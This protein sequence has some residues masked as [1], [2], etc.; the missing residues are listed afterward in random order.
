M[1]NLK[2]LSEIFEHRLVRIPD[3][4][5]GYAWGKPQL[6][7]FWEDLL[8]LNSDRVH[9]TGVITLEPVDEKFYARWD[10][11]LWLIKGRGYKPFYVVD[12]QQR[13]T[14]SL[15]LIQAIL[16]SID[17]DLELNYQGKAEIKKHYIL[18][19]GKDGVRKSFFFGYEKDNPSSEF[20]K[21]SI[22]GEYSASNEDTLTLYTKNLADAKAFFQKKLV[23]M[24]DSIKAK[25]FKKLTQKFKFNLYEVD[26]EIDVFVTFETMNNRGKPLSH[27]ELL[28]NR[29][30]YL[31]TLFPEHEGHQA[32]R[33]II[34]NSW[35]SIYEHLGKNPKRI[36]SDDEYLRSHWAMYFTYTRNKGNDYI[37]YLLNKKFTA[38]NV[39]HPDKEEER[40]TVAEISEYV[41]S[42]Q[43]SITPWFYM[44]NP[45][46]G[47]HEYDNEQNQQLLEKLNRLSF[48][49]FRPLIL[50]SYRVDLSVQDS[51]RLL[52]SIERLIFSLFEL[53][54]RRSNTGDSKFIGIAR[55]L[56]NG[57][58]T[59]D[60]VIQEIESYTNDYYSS[61]RFK[62]LITEKYKVG[63]QEGFYAWNGLRYLL[64][65]YETELRNKGK[66]SLEKLD[67]DKLNSY[68][69]DHVTVEHIY[70]QT[71]S[72]P[73][74]KDFIIY[75]DQ[76]KH[77]LT[78]SLGNLLPLSR[79][80]NSSLQ[81]FSFA[82]KKDNGEG[83]GYYNG[84]ISENEVSKMRSWT[85]CEI[86]E[87][88][89]ELLNFIERRW[90]LSLGDEQKKKE[91]LCL[92]FV[93][94]AVSTATH[95]LNEDALSV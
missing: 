28:K 14:T 70:P 39:T 29:L 43:L 4:Q 89:L 73:W 12:G 71:A 48:R 17:D 62:S 19:E 85:A 94:P 55:Q 92:T 95:E 36:L 49:Y 24:G 56:H 3:Y 1:S 34:N 54:Q 15:I 40:L 61:D 44:H 69:K 75:D 45:Y 59:I 83:V 84:S 51:N 52:S 37:E 65:E 33:T 47:M 46:L 41:K 7:H 68:K 60:D 5:R 30:I 79:S 42:L 53:S 18:E 21:S 63:S 58:I 20:L 13:L 86:L 93:K 31:S 80:K 72:E 32:L 74:Q 6:E 88:G 25:V 38:K 16:E 9:Y 27:L 50:A 8:Q 78:H 2:S 77:F 81:N 90:N 35:K 22:F 26:P 67:W 76:Q 64:F 66:Q 11:D 57:E 82:V 23:N 91:V 10:E 87:R